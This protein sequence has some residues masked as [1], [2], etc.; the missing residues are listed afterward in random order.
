MKWPQNLGTILAFAVT[1]CSGIVVTISKLVLRL[2]PVS[3][4]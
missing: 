2:A 3:S 1:I 4:D